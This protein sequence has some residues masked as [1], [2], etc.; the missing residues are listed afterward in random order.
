MLANDSGLNFG[1]ATT[2]SAS[3]TITSD[4]LTPGAGVT[5]SLGTLIINTST[6][7][8]A[9]GSNV[10]SGT[11]GL[12][13]ANVAFTGSPTFF[14]GSGTTLQL[15]ATTFNSHTFTKSGAGT[16]VLS[17]GAS[18]LAA[19][20]TNYQ[21]LISGGTIQANANDVADQVATPKQPILTIRQAEPL[22]SMHKPSIK[23]F[24]IS[25]S[26]ADTT[27]A[28]APAQ[29]GRPAR[30]RISPA[31]ARSRSLAPPHKLSSTAA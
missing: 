19:N 1:N 28:P 18:N 21:L 2:I 4:R 26:A 22:R 16:L 15:G 8:T 7:S 27:S 24:S 10:T 12:T 3:T 31:A 11:A 13:F 9:A 20:T 29:R 6:L 30:P 17:A 23:A 5:H 14:V 25:S